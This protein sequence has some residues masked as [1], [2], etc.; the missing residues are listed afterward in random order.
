LFLDVL[1]EDVCI[2]CELAGRRIETV[3]L[4]RNG[5]ESFVSASRREEGGRGVDDDDDDDDGDVEKGTRREER[6]VVH[7][8][9]AGLKSTS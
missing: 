6:R 1:R 5:L 8:M 9:R 2:V 7:V 4:E 3:G